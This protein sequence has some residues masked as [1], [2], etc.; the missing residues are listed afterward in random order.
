MLTL[1]NLSSKPTPKHEP[2]MYWLYGQ[3]ELFLVLS[4]A[5]YLSVIASLLPGKF[6]HPDLVLRSNLRVPRYRFQFSFLTYRNPFVEILL[7]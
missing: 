5:D 4:K 3:A 6:P 1:A 2:K 7:P